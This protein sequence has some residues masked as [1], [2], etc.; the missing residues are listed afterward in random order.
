MNAELFEVAPFE[1]EQF[2]TA[3]VVADEVVAVLGQ[4]QR[5]EPR[6]HLLVAPLVDAETAQRQRL[7]SEL[8]KSSSYRFDSLCFSIPF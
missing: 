1:R 6:R 7:P 8:A 2:G 4:V 5:L 3:D